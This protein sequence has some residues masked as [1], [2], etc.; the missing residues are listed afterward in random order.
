MQRVDPPTRSEHGLRL[1]SSSTTGAESDSGGNRSDREW[2]RRLAEVFAGVADALQAAHETGVVHRDIKPS[3]LLLDADGVLK[4]VDFG[5]AHLDDPGPS[6]TLTGDLVGTPAY[7]S[8]EQAR[9]K[10]I[11]IDHRTDIYSLGAVLY[12]ML[13]LELPFQGE[14]REE[15]LSGVLTKDPRP[16]RRSNRKIPV[17]LETIC[18][19][20]MEK[21]P[22]QRYQSAGDMAQDLRQYLV[23]DLIAARRASLARRA[24]KWMRRHPVASVSTAALLVIGGT[25]AVASSALEGRRHEATERAI[26]DA[27]LM[28]VSGDHRAGLARI[29]EALLIEPENV[30]AQLVRA[31]LQL[32]QWHWQDALAGARWVLEREPENWEAHLVVASAGRR[33]GFPQVPVEEHLA[34][35]EARAPE[36]ADSLFL[37]GQ[38]AE[39]DSEAV[40]WLD[41]ALERDPGHALALAER[42]RR[43]AA[44]GRIPEALRD[45][46]RLIAARPRSAVGYQRRPC[47]PCGSTCLVGGLPPC[48]KKMIHQ[49]ST[50]D[51]VDQRRATPMTKLCTETA[52]LLSLFA[53]SAE[54]A[55]WTRFR[56][57]DGNGHANMAVAPVEWS[58]ERNVV[59]KAKLPGEGW[60]SPVAQGN[61]VYVT[62]AL[63]VRGSGEYSL[64]LLT[65]E[66]D[67]GKL[68]N[69]VEVFHQHRAAPQI[70]R[71][72]SHASPTPLIAEERVYVHFG[73]Q[74]TASVSLDGTIL[75]TNRDQQYDS[76]HGNGGSPILVDQAL[77]VSCDGQTD[78]Y[79]VA[80]DKDNGRVLWKKPRETNASKKF[81][82][83]TPTLI[84]VDG[85]PQ[86]ITAGSNAVLA[87]DPRSGREIWRVGYDGYSV[88]P[89]PVYGDG[90]LFL[91]TG[92]QTPRLL[93]IRVDGQGDV[94]D[95]HVMWEFDRG[96]PHTPSPLLDGKY[97]FVISDRGV[98]SCL[99]ARTGAVQWQ[100]RIGGSFSTSPLLADGKI[101]FQSE[102]GVT[103][104][105]AAD[106]EFHKLAENDLGERTL[107]SFAV[108]EGDFLIRGAEHLFRITAR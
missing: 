14:S 95:T 69:Q 23:G 94:T 102:D 58:A 66:G 45:A 98:A 101:Y 76:I 67:S 105:V 43:Q 93:A 59:W 77:I 89:K 20:A 53:A 48:V 18:L 21:S 75:W 11:P 86:L 99:L 44:L 96:A 3:N 63:P 24:W 51:P 70:H 5:L 46:D 22:D 8:P 108:L 52:L 56:G 83:S 9:G 85:H 55:D 15:V 16:P 2:F 40:A 30:E 4:I 28:L 27:R 31:R 84:S 60:S 32:P 6:M 68:V 62:A 65:V 35:V 106:A 100:E 79:I 10:R 39:S 72:N 25:V 41:R 34:R 37:R 1:L 82:F 19:K 87:L 71:K 104:V 42:S 49:S 90:L 26:A 107:A 81:S 92:Y 50:D 29:D 38:L 97:L 33:G 61:M 17:D 36:T 47:R 64:R 78:P 91:S 57:P 12:E 74:G 88:I 54:S 73:H 13:T 7:M 80:L 103:T